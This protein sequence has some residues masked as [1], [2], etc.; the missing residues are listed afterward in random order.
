MF[1]D[2]LEIVSLGGMMPGVSHDT[3]LAGVSVARNDKL[4]QIFLRLNIIE[5]FGTGIPRIFGAYEHSTRQPEIPVIDGG[6]L[7][8]IPNLNY[9]FGQEE[10]KGKTASTTSEQR[11]LSSFAHA[12][13][14]K[15]EAAEALKITPNGTYKLLQK[16]VKQGLLVAHKEGKQWIYS[17]HQV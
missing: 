10:V 12:N 8:C 7:I 16:L 1:D 15:E 13:F 14:S 11:L 17:V 3:M 4:A 6:F 2:R 5:V 9:R